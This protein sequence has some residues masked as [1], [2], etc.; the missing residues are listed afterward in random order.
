MT[1][2]AALATVDTL[3]AGAISLQ[4]VQTLLR[5]ANSSRR[6][7]TFTPTGVTADDPALTDVIRARAPEVTGFVQQ[8]VP[9]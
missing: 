4:S 1:R 8:A 5:Q 7:L 9:G 6:H 2:R 3:G